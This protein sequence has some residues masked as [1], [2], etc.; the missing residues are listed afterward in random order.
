MGR[1]QC[2]YV[3]YD[4]AVGKWRARRPSVC[5]VTKVFQGFADAKNYALAHLLPKS[6]HDAPNSRLR[7]VQL[8]RSM[9]KIYGHQDLM[10]ADLQDAVA[11][12]ICDSDVFE[13]EPAAEVLSIMLKYRLVRTAFSAALRAHGQV[14]KKRQVTVENRARRLWHCLRQVVV[15]AGKCGPNSHCNQSATAKACH[16]C[17][18]RNHSAICTLPCL[19]LL[20]HQHVE[21]QL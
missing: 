18:G 17:A 15:E 7:M 3:S 4:R 6:G 19:T 16:V 5:R 20:G 13:S 8:L 21:V 2:P 12:H 11:R 14:L 1:K 10:P 9:S